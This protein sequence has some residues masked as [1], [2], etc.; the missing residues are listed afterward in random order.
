[1]QNNCICCNHTQQIKVNPLKVGDYPW[2]E[3]SCDKCSNFN[4]IRHPDSSNN[5]YKFNINKL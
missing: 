1:M 2:I 3:Y 5:D 4:S